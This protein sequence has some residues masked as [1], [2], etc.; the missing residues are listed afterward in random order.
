[1]VLCGPEDEC[2]KIGRQII[3]F[4]AADLTA[5]AFQVYADTVGSR[6]FEIKGCRNSC[7]GRRDG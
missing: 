2:M 4:N 6:Q 3:V 1:M 7:A 5:E